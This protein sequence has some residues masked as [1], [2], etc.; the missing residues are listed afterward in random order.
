MQESTTLS[1]ISADPL[2]RKLL[3]GGLAVAIGIAF[4]VWPRYDTTAV[5]SFDGDAAGQVEAGVMTPDAKEPAVA[6]A[7]SIL[8]DEAVRELARQ[9]GVPFGGGET[10][11]VEF[12]SRLVMAQ[13]SARL[14]RVNYKDTDKKLS[15]AVANAVAN[16]LVAW[17]PSSVRQGAPSA[18]PALAKSGRQKRPLDS[19]S[20][21]LS[22]LESQLTV[23]D[24]KIAALYA[25]AI[26]LQKADAGAPPSTTENKHQRKV[27][28]DEIA[29]LRL[30]RT[31]LVGAIVAEKQREAAG[32]IWQR[33]F[34]LVQLAGDAG[35]S[36]SESGLL[37]YWP[38]AA[39]LC[40]FLYLGLVIWQYQP[41]ESAAA[42]ESPLLYDELSTEKTTEHFGSG[43][44]TE[45]PWTRT[46]APWAQTQDSW[47]QT[48]DSWTNEV[49]KTLSLTQLGREDEMFAAH[50]K[51]AA[52]LF[53]QR[54]VDSRMPD[55]TGTDLI[56]RSAGGHPLRYRKKPED[57][58]TIC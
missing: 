19:R 16:M 35:A 52:A 32:P 30:E 33:P 20:P 26:A 4:I 12:R 1:H 17:M 23:A 57:D 56:T 9:A 11:V 22:K 14:L 38:L 21:P 41:I 25:Q 53:S 18:N 24:R 49:L 28:A 2:R 50:H 48:D 3:A 51:P 27:D 15:A 36:Q 58:E 55:A 34:T 40:G 39:I 37:G 46:E 10:N 5:L 44:Q 8:S 54:Q 6:F 45:A 47:S 13:T 31:R 29:Q 7:S 42:L 43:I